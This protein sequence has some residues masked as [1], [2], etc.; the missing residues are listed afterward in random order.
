MEFTKG[1][2]YAHQEV[3]GVYA[4][5]G[6]RTC[7][8]GVDWVLFSVWQVSQPGWQGGAG[9]EVREFYA[10]YGLDGPYTQAVVDAATAAHRR[11]SKS[12]QELK[13]QRRIQGQRPVGMWVDEATYLPPTATVTMPLGVFMDFI[14]MLSDDQRRGLEETLGLRRESEADPHEP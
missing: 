6:E 9:L 2:I 14:G 1:E 11:V 7:R 8:G 5:V 4:R 12:V 13:T 10:T 3:D